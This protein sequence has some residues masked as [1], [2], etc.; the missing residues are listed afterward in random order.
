MQRLFSTFAN[1]L[2]GIGLLLLRFVTGGVLIHFAVLHLS[3]P[4]GLSRIVLLLV[5]AGAGILLLIGLW[6]PIVGTAIAVLELWVCI[7]IT[8]HPRIALLL[9][10]LGTSLALIGPGAW[11]V[12]ARIFGRKHIAVTHRPAT[13]YNESR[14]T[15]FRE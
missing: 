6:T 5:G 4:A 3:G 9:A 1:G 12:D 11:S 13:Q 2:P 14:S 7:S 8:P 15:R 10:V